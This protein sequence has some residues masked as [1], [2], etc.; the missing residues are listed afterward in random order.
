LCHCA[1][2]FGIA[3]KSLEDFETLGKELGTFMI[4]FEPPSIDASGPIGGWTLASQLE[5][6]TG[7]R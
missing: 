6:P 2:Q 4:F 1:I 5:L 3:I 7:S